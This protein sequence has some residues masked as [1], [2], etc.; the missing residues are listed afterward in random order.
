MAQIY[1]YP[2]RK[3]FIMGNTIVILSI[4]V[5]IFSC[6]I[7]KGR[8]DKTALQESIPLCLQQEMDAIKN[9]TTSNPPLQIEEYLCNDKRVF[10][11]MAD[12]CDQFNMLYDD[13]CKSICA[14]SGG[15]DG[16]GDRKC[17]DFSAN[18][19]HVKVTWKNTDK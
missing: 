1:S 9:K 4:L 11:Y 15:L 8:E 10:L 7:I 16:S 18:A 17:S 14:P 13:N 6:S 12:C 19:K 2:L 5:F 3:L